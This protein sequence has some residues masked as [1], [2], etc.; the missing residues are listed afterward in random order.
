MT[1]RKND[2]KKKRKDDKS[3]RHHIIPRSRGGKKGI[4]NMVTLTTKK[5]RDYHVLFENKTPEEIINYLVTDCWNGQWHHVEKMYDRIKYNKSKKT[6]K[7]MET[8][9]YQI[10]KLL[11]NR[12]KSDGRTI[13]LSK[14][15]DELESNKRGL[16]LEEECRLNGQ[17]EADIILRGPSNKY[18]YAIKVKTKGSKRKLKKAQAQLMHDK[19]YIEEITGIKKV[20]LF[21]VYQKHQ[22][23]PYTISRYIPQP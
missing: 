23:A 17:Y 10:I 2:D 5:H 9:H 19:K 20:F 8:R 12:L 4:E 6:S 21:Y 14:Y 7:Y 11:E 22:N 1:R 13:I 18:A 15:E 16:L 3:S